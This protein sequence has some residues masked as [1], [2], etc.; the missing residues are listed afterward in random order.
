MQKDNVNIAIN[1]DDNDIFQICEEIYFFDSTV[2]LYRTSH[3]DTF[4]G[5]P[6]KFLQY[7]YGKNESL[8]LSMGSIFNAILTQQTSAFLITRRE[9]D[10]LVRED[11]NHDLKRLPS[12]RLYTAIID[13]L[14]ESSVLELLEKP[15]KSKG[16]LYRV[17]KPQIVD[18]LKIVMVDLIY[19]DVEKKRIENYYKLSLKEV[20]EDF[21]ISDEEEEEYKRRYRERKQKKNN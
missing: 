18:L 19:E 6:L 5:R 21:S 14:L 11:P 3:L 9:L 13:R 12:T 17:I 1:E 15:T 16:G 7:W 4:N 2:K 10:T 20:D 8:A